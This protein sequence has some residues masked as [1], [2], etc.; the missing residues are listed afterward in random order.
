MKLSVDLLTPGKS[1]EEYADRKE[2]PDEITRKMLLADIFRLAGPAFMELMLTQI[3]SMAD[4]MMVGGLGTWAIS[5][6]SLTTQPKYLIMTLFSSLNVGTTALIARYIGMK[7]QE[8][9]NEVLR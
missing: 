7:R 8:A 9:A 6:V 3:T 2:Y 5:A 1:L 4:L